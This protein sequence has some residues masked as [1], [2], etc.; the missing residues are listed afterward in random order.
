MQQQQQQRRRRRKKEDADTDAVAVEVQQ[1]QQQQQVEL[2]LEEGLWEWLIPSLLVT[3]CDGIKTN[4]RSVRELKDILEDEDDNKNTTTNVTTTTNNII[5]V[6]YQSVNPYDISGDNGI[7]SVPAAAAAA[8]VL[9]NTTPSSVDDD[10]DDNGR[11]PRWTESEEDLL[12]RCETTL[13]RILQDNSNS[14]SNS[15][16]S[17]S[18]SNSNTNAGESICIVSHAPCDQAMAYYLETGSE[19]PQ[20]SK[21]TPWPLGGITMFSRPIFYDDDDDDDHKNDETETETETE[22]ENNQPS[23]AV[24]GFGEWT[25]ELYGNTKHMPGDYK[26]GLKEWSLPCFTK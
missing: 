22:T 5:A 8:V 9:E 1:Q 3:K 10:D 17:N 21:L 12:R 24:S 6:D 26:N 14:N 15:N 20:D 19:T 16:N 11:P 25:M 7:V 23:T 4:P 2:R 18:N 13:S